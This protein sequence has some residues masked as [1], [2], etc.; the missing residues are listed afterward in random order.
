MAD[1]VSR[2]VLDDRLNKEYANLLL[3]TEEVDPFVEGFKSA[4][5][6][7]E[8]TTNAANVLPV[9]YCPYCGAKMKFEDDHEGL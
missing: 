5:N 8:C 7:V 1:Y 3:D 4:I 9:R 2:E 6:I